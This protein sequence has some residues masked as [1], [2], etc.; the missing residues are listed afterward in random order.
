M[1]RRLAIIAL[2]LLAACGRGAEVP[3][4]EEPKELQAD[5][6]VTGM[7]HF[8]TANGVRQAL[9]LADTAFFF[10]ETK[11]IELRKVEL[12]IFN[13]AGEVAATV[14]SE[15]ALIDPRTEKVDAKGNV[16]VVSPEEDQRIESDE[17]HYD[18]AKD[19]IWSDLP[20]TYIRNGRITHG[21]GFTSDGRGE[22]VRVTSPRGHVDA[23]R[24]GF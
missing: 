24:L 16:V 4:G 13:A 9:L 17:L 22:N 19:R 5:K 21:D 1:M 10:D 6:V 8:I 20:T 11:P 3:T 7:R 18:P 23:P 14:T 12:T 2:A 15:S